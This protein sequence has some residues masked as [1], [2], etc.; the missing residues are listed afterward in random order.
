MQPLAISH[1]SLEPP[2]GEWREAWRWRWRWVDA[3]VVVMQVPAPQ[4][5][6]LLWAS[7]LAMWLGHLTQ[8]EVTPWQIAP[9]NLWPTWVDCHYVIWSLLGLSPSLNWTKE[10]PDVHVTIE[11]CVPQ[12]ES[13]QCIV[14]FCDPVFITRTRVERRRERERSCLE[15]S[16]TLC[17]SLH[18]LCPIRSAHPPPPHDFL[19]LS[20]SLSFSLSLGCLT[21]FLLWL[22]F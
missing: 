10:V 6:K 19:S 5:V 8:N 15:M 3:V 21:W 12:N 1:E 2:F 14:Q 17:L 4:S 22:A 16:Y 9:M 7:V 18:F 13:P 11:Y 20:L